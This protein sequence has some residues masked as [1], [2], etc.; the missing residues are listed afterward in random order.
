MPEVWSIAIYRGTSPLT[1]APSGVVITGRDVT[2]VDAASVADPFLIRRDGRWFLFFEVIPRHNHRGGVIA[3]AESD[4]AVRWR[5]G[6]VILREPFHLSY[7]HV[8]EWDGETYM[9]PENAHGV[10][11]YRCSEFPRVWRYAGDLLSIEGADPTLFWF[12]GRWFLFVYTGPDTLRLFFS[13]ELTGRYREHP[14]SPIV[15]DD[16]CARPAGR[17]IIHDGVPLRFA[18]VG[19]PSYG[20]AVRAFRIT[21]LTP[22][23][24]RE[25]EAATAPILTASGAGWNANGMHHIDAHQLEDGTWIGAVDGRGSLIDGVE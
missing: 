24:Y 3:F 16:T 14:S 23:S 9:T 6:G 7:P 11:L 12:E 19:R 13:D 10:R 8:F 4:D 20:T 21:E 18:Q 25:E 2:D 22:T 15:A 5:Y 1:L 17:I